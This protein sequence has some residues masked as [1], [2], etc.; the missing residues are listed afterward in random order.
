[1]RAYVDKSFDPRPVSDRPFHVGIIRVALV[2]AAVI[3][4]GAASP[5]T[6]LAQHR[7]GGGHGGGWHGG[8]GGWHGGGG[9]PHPGGGHGNQFHR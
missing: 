8:G 3:A 6:A 4:I 2:V 1:M 9:G 7:G 5:Q